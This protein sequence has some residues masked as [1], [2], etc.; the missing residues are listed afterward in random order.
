MTLDPNTLDNFNRNTLPKEMLIRIESE[1]LHNKV[2][3]A[4][5]STLMQ[6]YL[7]R[8]DIDDLIGEDEE[9]DNLWKENKKNIDLYG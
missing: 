9:N 4:S 8:P 7:T 6:E 1:M 5:F 2:A 3:N